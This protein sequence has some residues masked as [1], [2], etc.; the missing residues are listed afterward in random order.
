MQWKLYPKTVNSMHLRFVFYLG[1]FPNHFCHQSR[2]KLKRR[3]FLN[4]ALRPL[5][6]KTSV[7]VLGKLCLECSAEGAFFIEMENDGCFYSKSHLL[8]YI[9]HHHLVMIHTTHANH[10]SQSDGTSVVWVISLGCNSR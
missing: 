3:S 10:I 8:D 6:N 2:C 4:L 5:N 9:H 1:Y 7:R